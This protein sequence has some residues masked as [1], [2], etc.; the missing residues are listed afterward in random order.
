MRHTITILMLLLAAAANAA[1]YT[2]YNV[3]GQAT[4]EAGGRQAPL[5]A[6]ATIDDATKLTLGRASAVTV[7][8]QKANRM[9]NF[10]QQGTATIGSLLASKRHTSKNLTKQYMGY[11]SKQLF[12]KGSQKMSHPDTYMQ[13][14]A[15]AYRSATTDSMLLATVAA[16]AGKAQGQSVEMRLADKANIVAGDYDVAFQLVACDTGEPLAANVKPG[17]PCYVKVSNKT[18][19]M[20]YVNVL[21]IDAKGGKYLVLPVDEAG[22]CAHLLVPPMCEVG[23]EGEPMIFSD[24]PADESFLL[25]ATKEPADFSIL[26]S[27]IPDTAHKTMPAGLCRQQYQVR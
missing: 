13:A 16:A 26:M 11:L 24:E 2:V 22:T 1:Q 21:D 9:Y 27:P 12:A 14:V 6:R 4:I 3:I 10:T 19:E 7:L 8:D 18:Q 23:F 5:K 20:L 15:T 25:I 17:Q